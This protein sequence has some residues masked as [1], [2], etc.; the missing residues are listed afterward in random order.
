MSREVDNF[1][2]VEALKAWFATGAHERHPHG[3]DFDPDILA[4][5]F[6]EGV[7]V[8]ELLKPTDD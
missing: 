4:K 1:P 6:H 8:S 2:N 3:V 5:K 7:P